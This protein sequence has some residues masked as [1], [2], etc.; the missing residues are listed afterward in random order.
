VFQIA[1]H[2]PPPQIR[3]SKVAQQTDRVE[4]ADP[5]NVVSLSKKSVLVIAE[6][7]VLRYQL[8]EKAPQRYAAV[9]VRGPLFVS[10]DPRAVDGFWLRTLGED[11]PQHY[12]LSSLALG[13]AGVPRVRA[14]LPRSVAGA[15]DAGAPSEAAPLA[16]A[17]SLPGV[18]IDTATDG[19]RVGVLS[20]ELVGDTYQPALAVFSQGKEEARLKLGPSV[21]LQLQP[22]LDLCL[23][24]GRPWVVVGNTQWLQLLDWSSRRLLAEW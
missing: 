14:E 22:K 18:L 19:D 6:A 24:P 13:D 7:A 11:E 5:L 16:F 17:A 10:L 9:P 2:L 3:G 1:E 20:M 8:G 4:L 21:G 15:L 12:A 23:I